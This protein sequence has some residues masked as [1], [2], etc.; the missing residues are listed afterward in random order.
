MRVNEAEFFLLLTFF[1]FLV[2]G[3]AAIVNVI[4]FQ[5]RYQKKVDTI[6][7]GDRYIDG[8]WMFNST[9]LMMYAHYCLF[10]RRA[11]RAGI[12]DRVDSIP[13][14]IKFH[15]VLH[16]FLVIVTC[17]LGGVGYLIVEFVL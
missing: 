3:V 17:F 2:C 14:V 7:Q 9:R 10:P 12:S 15:L 13:R 4:Y 16:W 8:G 1:I 6:I 5:I 11:L